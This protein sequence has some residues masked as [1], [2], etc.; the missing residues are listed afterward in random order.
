M[1]ENH[2]VLLSLDAEL[3]SLRSA[4]S[5]QP[6]EQTRYQLV[7]LE[8]LINQWVPARSSQN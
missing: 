2:P 6:N 8:Q 4:Y 7:R 5:Q 3:S 1:N